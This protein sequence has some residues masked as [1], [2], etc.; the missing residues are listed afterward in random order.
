MAVE[1]VRGCGYRQVGGTYL[2]GGVLSAPCDRLPYPLAACPICGQGIKI[3][4]A[5][6]E[7]NAFELFGIHKNC[8]DKVTP[9]VMCHPPRNRTSYIMIVGERHYP[10]PQDFIKEGR[11]LGV[12]KR[13]P[14]IPKGLKLKQTVIYLAHHKAIIKNGNGKSDK[15]GQAQMLEYQTGIFCAFIPSKIEKLVWESQ[16]KGK[17]GSELKKSLKKRGITPVAIPDKDKDHA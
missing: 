17:K 12:S 9:C 3:G 10:T 7:I 5:F 16:L 2:V 1:P 14:F 4:R 6:T 15:K 13:I 11:K 8:T